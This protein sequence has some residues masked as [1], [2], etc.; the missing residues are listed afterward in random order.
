MQKII[1]NA[2]LINEGE[3]FIG[4][5][6]I[7]N[8]IIKTVFKGNPEF[9]PEGEI[10]DAIGKWLL[11]GVIDD[12]VHFREPGATDKADIASESAAAVAGG[13]TSYMDMPNNIP[14]ITTL[15]LLERKYERA[16]ETSLANYSF[17][18]GANNEN[19]EEIKRINP[20]KVCGVK[21]FMGSSTGNMLV[22]DNH[23]LSAI[24]DQSPVL[25][26]AHCEDEDIIKKNLQNV[27]SRCGDNIPPS[28][29]PLI[30]NENACVRSTAKALNL[31]MKY[32]SRLH[33]LHLTTANEARNFPH[34]EHITAEVCVHHLWFFDEDYEQ[35]GNL[36]KCNPAI[37][38]INDCEELRKAVF[39]GNIA[40]I[41][42]DHAPH[43]LEDKQKP[44][45]QAPSGI[46]MI[47]HTLP[48]M[49]ELCRRNIFTPALVVER[50]CHAPA[51]IFNIKQRGFIREG[52][53]A[54]LVL[55]DPK[56]SYTINKEN[57]FYKCGWSPFE[58]RQFH[59]QITHTFV[60]G[61]LVYENGIIN[62]EHKGMRLTFER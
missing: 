4:G 49:F 47:Q 7:E 15:E 43:L 40:V 42:S 32:K 34:D 9:I 58:G 16:A 62:K 53:Y 45:L 31:A 24:F 29:H 14:L 12:H 25:I 55:V 52:Y 30:R 23:I 38:T 5:V 19:S 60:N 28:Y 48:A 59:T 36:I 18:L 50:M 61:N 27:I 2:T 56:T 57:I 17:Y 1:I 6:I 35:L 11:P 21:V 33:V 37:K 54:D 44:Y 39:N 3:T 26:A 8:E 41:G 20:A 46:P 22:D 51:R 10:I 13:V